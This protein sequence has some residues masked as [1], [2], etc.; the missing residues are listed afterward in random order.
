MRLIKLQVDNLLGLFLPLVVATAFSCD[1]GE[2]FV[3]EPGPELASLPDTVSVIMEPG[4]DPRLPE[5]QPDLDGKLTFIPFADLSFEHQSAAVYD[6]YAFFVRN[7]RG[8]ICL[9]DMDRKSKIYTLSPGGGGDLSIYHSNQSS[10][11]IE[12]YEPS[13]FFPLLYISQRAKSNK[14]CFTEVFRIIPLFNADSTLLAFRTELVQ[15]IY[16]PPMTEQNSLGNVNAVIDGKTGWLY[17]YSRNNESTDSNYGQCK[18]S[19]FAIPDVHQKEAY[20]EDT[21]IESSFMIDARATNMQGGCIVD[22]RL[23]IGQG[24]P[25]TG[26]VYLNVVDLQKQKLVKRY[27]LMA[28]GIDWEPEGCFYYDGSV[29]LTHT[30]A[31]C[32]VE[33]EE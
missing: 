8:T 7:G 23:Y 17:T 20:L 26:S 15:E 19:R 5:P 11:G 21:D 10:F 33:E 12:K 2:F 28:K 32:R 14:R 16:F 31:I 9:F 27:D 3:L 1:K 24:Y 22:D 29:M 6:K 18:I 4:S 30:H 25:A 13:D